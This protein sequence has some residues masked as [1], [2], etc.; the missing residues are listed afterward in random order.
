MY[1][2]RSGY[3]NPRAGQSQFKSCIYLEKQVKY[4][5]MSHRKFQKIFKSLGM[6]SKYS[7][8]YY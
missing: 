4:F 2:M 3:E 1:M 8:T 7:S 5:T 6:Y